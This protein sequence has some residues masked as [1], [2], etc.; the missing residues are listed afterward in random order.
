MTTTTGFSDVDG[1]GM[2]DDLVDYLA[3]MADR[4]AAYRHEGLELLNLSPG[5]AV[6]DVGCG[7][8]EICVDLA[9]RVGPAGRIAGVDVSEA[10]IEAARR[11]ATSAR[12]NIDLRVASAYQLPF[13]DQSFDVVR[14]ER[15]FQHL[16]EPE[17]ALMEMLRVTRIGGQVMLVDPDHGQFSV[18]VDDPGERKVFEAARRSLLRMIVN[19]HSGIRLR[20]LL[21]RAGL[22]EIRHLTRI[23]DVAYADFARAYFL[24]DLLAAAMAANEISQVDVE[25]FVA[26]LKN[27]DR[28]GTFLANAVGYTVVGTRMH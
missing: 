21:Q 4:L 27:R 13:A 26:A 22:G 6:L 16:A 12:C 8:G 17:A 11:A 25:R 7:A 20:A 14:A 2:S 19:P 9:D 28:T 10:M 3:L 15:V 24:H 23:L 1:S 5:S 18:A